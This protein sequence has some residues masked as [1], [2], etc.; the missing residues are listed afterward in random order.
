MTSDAIL[1]ELRSLPGAPEGLRERVRA[2][3]EPKPRFAWTLP[4]IDVRRVVLVAAPAILAI[5]FGAAALNGLVEGSSTSPQPVALQAE[6]H[7]ANG[8]GATLR[9]GTEKAPPTFKAATVPTFA[10][11]PLD[12][13]QALPP[14]TTRL[15]KYNAWLRVRVDADRLSKATSS[16][17][18]IARGYGGYV[19]SVDMNTPGKSGTASLV[20]RIPV[21][22][23]EDAVLRLGNLGE[24]KAQRV[25][26]EDLQ[27][28]ANQLE[29]EILKLQ[30]TI[31]GLQ[32]KLGGNLSAEDRLRLRYQLDAAKQ[33]LAQKTK[34]HTSTVREGT[35]ATVS[36]TFVAPQAAAAVPNRPGRLDRTISNAGDFLVRE[37]SWILYALIVV[38]PIAVLAAVA[39]FGVR[40]ARRR[41]DARLLESA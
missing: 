8:D 26:I 10:P 1:T 21:T 39:V 31:I 28:Q 17:M 33:E 40:S 7:G 41:S 22:K 14:S 11:A 2:L 19:A 4:R 20:L 23:V 34:A 15:N 30:T 6:Q 35:L 16:A 3:P 27:R 12:R 37:L 36:L 29:R 32:R 24:V 9:A 13:A 5:G 18:K 25:R 38:G